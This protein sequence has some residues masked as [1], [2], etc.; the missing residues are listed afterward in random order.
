MVRS[1]WK[2]QPYY[3]SRV[4]LHS[5]F[6]TYISKGGKDI[7]YKLCTKCKKVHKIGTRCNI[8]DIKPKAMDNADKIQ[9]FYNT[10]QWR[11]TRDNVKIRDGCCIRC[12]VKFKKFNNTKLEV[13]HI[14]KLS[15]VIGWDNRYKEDKLIT[16]CQKCHRYVN[17]FNNGKLDFTL[18]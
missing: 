13:H 6:F 11:R 14:Y 5:I 1:I 2:L 9:M 10:S 3:R 17:V 12:L 7:S 4:F 16:L 18:E 15:T 8:K